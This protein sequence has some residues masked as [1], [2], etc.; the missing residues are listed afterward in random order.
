MPEQDH[1]NGIREALYFVGAC[2]LVSTVLRGCVHYS[3]NP[4]DT[5]LR[6]INT[7][8]HSLVSEVD[9]IGK[10]VEGVDM[11]LKDIDYNLQNRGV[12]VKTQKQE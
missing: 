2:I 4:I 8:L 12:K 5:R 3:R 9:N 11:L 10:K 1:Y 6:E 7:N